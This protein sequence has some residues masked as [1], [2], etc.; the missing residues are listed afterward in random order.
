[1]RDD[2]QGGLLATLIAAP[3]VMVCCGGSGVV[4]AAITAALGSWFSGAGGFALFLVASAA[5][6]TW[7]SVRRARATSVLPTT[8]LEERVIE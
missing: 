3:V 8:E 7:R 1:M 5:A 6:L 4:L 2:L